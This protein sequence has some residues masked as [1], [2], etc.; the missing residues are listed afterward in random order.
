MAARLWSVAV[1]GWALAA[2]PAAA[3]ERPFELADIHRIVDLTEPVFSPDGDWIAFTAATHDTAKDAIRGAIW[4]VS[5]DGK[6]KRQ[7]TT[8]PD[9]DES[10][11]RWTPD[12]TRL[13]FLSGGGD[14]PAQ[15]WVRPVGGGAARQVTHMPE[16]VSDFAL[17]PDGR[18]LALI[19]DDAKEAAPKGRK[20]PPLVTER[21]LFMDDDEGYLD[22]HRH[23]LYL[24]D[25]GGGEPVAL[26]SG[27]GDEWL[28]QFSRDGA[29]IA[30]V[31]KRGPDA[32]R[33]M[34]FDIYWV[35]ARA[36]AAE[37][38]LTTFPGSDCDPYWGSRPD[39]SP[40]GTK[41]A[42]LQ[43]GVEQW[44]EFA[45]QILTVIDV[46][47]GETSQPAPI[48]RAFYNPKWAPDGKS[49]YARIEQAEDTFLARIDAG[50]GRV[51]YLTEGKR[52]DADFDIGPHGRVA[53]LGGDA[54]S[55]YEISAVEGQLRPLSRMNDAW[56]AGVRLRPYEDFSFKADDG[57]DI[58]G[59]LV[60]PDGAAPGRKLPAIVRLHGGPVYQFSHE[61]M[62]DWQ[63]FA[64]RGYAVVAINPRGSSGRGF[65]FAK[66]IHGDW[67]HEDAKDILAGTDWAVAQ[68][69]ADPD[70]LG[71]GGWSYGGMLTDYV[72]ATDRRFKAAISGA[73]TANM[74]GNYGVD[75]YV[76]D[77]ETQLGTPWRNLDAY[78]RVSFPFVHADRI[79]T[80]TL[81][82]CAGDDMNV[83]CN[84]AE[85]MYQ[86]LGS[87][88]VPTRF[89]RFPKQHHELTVPS[90]L[91]FRLKAYVDWYDR[92]LKP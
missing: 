21:F 49:I 23:H 78:L 1:F 68:G 83:P 24:A 13:V 19:A 44:G 73:G 25:L 74:L 18:H 2:L 54:A 86:A 9:A 32:D 89:I 76:E 37:H 36:G 81:F 85:Q 53:V 8:G 82:L 12:G 92:F 3:G 43:G 17:S 29:R 58:H 55:P 63:Y 39:W 28:P 47:S 77:Y 67:G 46:A 71:V 48:D 91:E 7:F 72:I 90:Y 84:G 61:F 6:R 56:L 40:D 16:G 11:P 80:P 5:W 42:Y 22:E 20:E 65:D 79:T 27:P 51:T 66:V 45:P 10:H 50:S 14:D 35:E 60:R 62:D 33:H 88:R 87:L 15:I 70:R 57:T 30:Y 75:E 4:L 69:G 38:Q 52:F 31:S 34:N 41:I 64:A 59:M 26:S